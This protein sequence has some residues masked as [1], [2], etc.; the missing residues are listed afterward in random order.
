MGNRSI[1]LMRQ[2]TGFY[3][4]AAQ[5]LEAEDLISALVTLA[6]VTEEMT[7]VP[8]YTILDSVGQSISKI[9][10]AKEEA[11]KKEHQKLLGDRIP[12]ITRTD[13]EL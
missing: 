10:Q 12:A 9:K 6:L 7:E 3:Q 8:V 13:T 11:F 5:D 1:S 4:V 2:P